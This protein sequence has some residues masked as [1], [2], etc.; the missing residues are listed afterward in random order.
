MPKFGEF[1]VPDFI[2]DGGARPLASKGS[3]ALV[4]A[5]ALGIFV[6]M[7]AV[8]LGMGLWSTARPTVAQL[9]IVGGF[10]RSG[11]NDMPARWGGV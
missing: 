11:G 1:Q 10:V 6:M 3:A 5:I 9:P 8:S 2:D 4:V 7:L